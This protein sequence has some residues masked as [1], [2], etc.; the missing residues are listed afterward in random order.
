MTNKIV[1]KL[2][3]MVEQDLPSLAKNIIVPANDGYEAFGVYHI[4]KNRGRFRVEKYAAIVGDFSHMRTALSWC[5][6]DKY[7]QHR[8]ADDILRLDQV[9]QTLGD[10]LQVRTR[11]AQ[12]LKPANRAEAIKIKIDRKRM[13]IEDVKFRLDKCINLAKYWQL[14]GFNNE[15]A[16]AGRTTSHRTYR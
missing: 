15:T 4:C 13:A 5:V 7:H 16:R 10:D 14:R 1:Q 12:S 9:H 6:A 11:L 3:R 2:A 8:L